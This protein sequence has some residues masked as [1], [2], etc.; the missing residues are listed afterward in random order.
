MPESFM[1]C[2]IGGFPFRDSA[3]WTIDFD[4]RGPGN[5]SKPVRQTHYDLIGEGLRSRQ[6]PQ[7]FASTEP[8]S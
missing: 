5:Q 8:S 1:S 4:R 7:T 2:S 6:G 3:L